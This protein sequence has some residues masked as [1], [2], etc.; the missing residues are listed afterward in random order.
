MKKR[1][2]LWVI[3]R[4][5]DEDEPFSHSIVTGKKVEW[6]SQAEFYRWFGFRLKPGETYNIR[7]EVDG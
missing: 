5:I 6:C 4:T 1:K 7:W 3:R 2:G